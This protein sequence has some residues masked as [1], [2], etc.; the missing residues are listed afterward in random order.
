MEWDG[1]LAGEGRGDS[2]YIFFTFTHPHL[3]GRCETSITIRNLLICRIVMSGRIPRGK[4]LIRL[5]FN[6]FLIEKIDLSK[7]SV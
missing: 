2:D 4:Q 5:I 6:Q 3:S 1:G 7:K